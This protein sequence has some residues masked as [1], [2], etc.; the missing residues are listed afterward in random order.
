MTTIYVLILNDSSF[1]EADIRRPLIATTN[2]KQLQYL[3]DRVKRATTDTRCDAS[4]YIDKIEYQGRYAQHACFIHLDSSDMN[5]SYQHYEHLMIETPKSL[6]KLESELDKFKKKD[7][8][9]S[10]SIQY[11]TILP[12]L[13]YSDIKKCLSH[14]HSDFF[15]LEK[16]YFKKLDGSY[17]QEMYSQGL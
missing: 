17:Y 8:S 16:D 13:S 2:L 12:S 5:Y 1:M 11:L 14:I 6:K 7:S 15:Q 9:I 3:V 4:F 10:Y